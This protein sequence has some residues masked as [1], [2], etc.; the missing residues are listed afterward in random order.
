MRT[1]VLEEAF[2]SYEIVR[3]EG[4]RVVAVDRLEEQ[5]PKVVVY[6]EAWQQEGVP[7]T[8]VHIDPDNDVV[9]SCGADGH[10]SVESQPVDA[11]VML[12]EGGEIRAYR[13]QALRR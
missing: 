1:A 6:T 3:L 7:A 2:G 12:V 5:G 13:K 8:C 4:L 9:L 10:W 11:R